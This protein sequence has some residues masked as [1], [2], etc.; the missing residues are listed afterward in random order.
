MKAVLVQCLLFAALVA[1]SPGQTEMKS[2]PKRPSTAAPM[3]QASA[4]SPSGKKNLYVVEL[5]A[6]RFAVFISSDGNTQLIAWWELATTN[7]PKLDCR[8]ASDGRC[9]ISIDRMAGH[10]VW[11]DGGWQR[12]FLRPKMPPYDPRNDH[13]MPSPS[14]DLLSKDLPRSRVDALPEIAALETMRRLAELHTEATQLRLQ[15]PPARQ[16]PNVRPMPSPSPDLPSKDL[17]SPPVDPSPGEY[18][19]KEQPG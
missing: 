17:P 11:S 13:T 3:N 10:F 4:V 1:A 18:F 16:P 8:W 7:D 6:S 5:S 2:D 14:A 12:M 15:K 19:K 9:W